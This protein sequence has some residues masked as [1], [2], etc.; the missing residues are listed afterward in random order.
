MYRTCQKRHCFRITFQAD[1]YFPN[2]RQQRQA[3]RNWSGERLVVAV[4]IG[5]GLVCFTRTQSSDILRDYPDILS[6]TGVIVAY[7]GVGGV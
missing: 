5:L 6:Q 1:A 7:W 3:L 4:G 2:P